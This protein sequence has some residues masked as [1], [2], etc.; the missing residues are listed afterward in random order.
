[1]HKMFNFKRIGNSMFA[2]KECS[3][4]KRPGNLRGKGTKS[5]APMPRAIVAR[6]AYFIIFSMVLFFAISCGGTGISSINEGSGDKVESQRN[7]ALPNFSEEILEGYSSEEALVKDITLAGNFYAKQII[8]SYR[9]SK[10]DFAIVSS[11]D[12]GA[13]GSGG[14]TVTE[15]S[16]QEAI[17][18]SQNSGTSADSSGYEANNQV[19]GVDEGDIVKSDGTRVYI[20]YGDELIVHDLD[21]KILD[22]V[23]LNQLFDQTS[24]N[25][26]IRALLVEDDRIVTVSSGYSTGVPYGDDGISLLKRDDD[27]TLSLLENK[28]MTGS[29]RKPRNSSISL[30]NHLRQYFPG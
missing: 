12:S 19:S 5:L 10:N 13:I 29:N 18:S 6:S 2:G 20:A 23:K 14:V 16:V 4:L 28:K 1:M 25:E 24:N 3:A 27:N 17:A 22:H 9:N 30:N 7:K 15:S 21:G 11:P 8:S 26:N